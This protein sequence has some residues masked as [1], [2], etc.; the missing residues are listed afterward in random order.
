VNAYATIRAALDMSK[1]ASR[2][3]VLPGLERKTDEALAELAERERAA[4]A[5]VMW[6]YLDTQHVQ[7][8]PPPPSDVWRALYAAPPIPAGMVELREPTEDECER[9]GAEFHRLLNRD[10]TSLGRD[11]FDAVSKWLKGEL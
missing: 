10:E 8:D 2:Y 4:S 7:I 3:C 9:I 1:R 6:Q 11:M 5:P